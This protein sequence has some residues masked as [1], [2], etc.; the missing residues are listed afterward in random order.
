MQISESEQAM[1]RETPSSRETQRSA[2]PAHSAWSLEKRIAATILISF[3]VLIPCFWLP[4]IEA[5]DL[6]S[7]TYNAWL[8]SLVEK[9]AAPGLWIAPQSNNI[10]TDVLLL[11]VGKLAGF[12]LSEKIV[13]AFAVLLFVWGGFALATAASGRAAWQ[14]VPLLSMLAYGWTFHMGFFNFYFSLGISF[15]ALAI[16][17]KC[18]LRWYALALLLVPLLWLAHPLGCAW[19]LGTA[20]YL[21]IAKWLNPRFHWI[22]FVAAVSTVLAIRFYL[23]GHY[24]IRGWSG[25]YYNL[26]GSDQLILGLAYSLVSELVL[27]AVAGCVLVHL[28][29]SFGRLRSWTDYFPLPLQLFLAG[30]FSLPFIP[31]RIWFPQYA[32]PVSFIC[33]RFTLAVGALGCCALACMRPRILLA[34]LTGGV[35]LTYFTFVYEDAA[36]T[37]ALGK[38]ADTLV[39]KL[40]QDARVIAT[41]FPFRDFR[42]FTHHVVDRAC[43]GHCFNI[44]NYEASSTQFRLRANP[45]NRFVAANPLDTSHMMLGDY[46]VKAE[47]L[48]LWQ[49]FQ[50]GPTE[51]DLCLRPLRVGPLVNFV[52]SE[53]VRA[54][55]LP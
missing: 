47:D 38:Q 29:Q 34:V 5:G 6:A 9:G 46:V 10:L 31:D 8:V 53:A 14:V 17:W 1:K 26:N 2:V 27:L 51:V 16:L 37:L 33:S 55:A 23:L 18:H 15:V 41:I 30:L 22:V 36:R 13:A 44:A 11:E 42:I 12:S 28:L 40:P 21:L 39:A 35:A 52:S 32:E 24:Q 25:Q 49:I 3:V 48:P 4:R 45:G 54:R 43:L 19:F 20:A 7:H 50:C